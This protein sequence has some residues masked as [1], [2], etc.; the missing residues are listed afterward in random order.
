[1]SSTNQNSTPFIRLDLTPEA[2]FKAESGEEYPAGRL[3][4]EMNCDADMDDGTD[5]VI[6]RLKYRRK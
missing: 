5:C 6:P 3:Y 2:A 1:M 4:L